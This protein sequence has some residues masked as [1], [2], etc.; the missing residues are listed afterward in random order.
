MTS[1]RSLKLTRKNSSCGLAVLKNCKAASLALPILLTMLPLRSKMTPT[2]MGTS[3]E[4][5]NSI[6]SST[7]FSKIRKL[8]GSRPVTR[9]SCGSV[10][11]TLISAK[12]TSMWRD[13]PFLITWPG[14][15]CLTSSRTVDWATVSTGKFQMAMPKSRRETNETK[16]TRVGNALLFTRSPLHRL[17]EC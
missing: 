4:E 13:W 10:T 12:S 6:S 16:K 9:R 2:E 3:S 15:S 1:A 5:K 11:V 7:L 8:S 14:V 17:S